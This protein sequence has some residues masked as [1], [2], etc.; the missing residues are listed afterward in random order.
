MQPVAI[1][2]TLRLLYLDVIDVMIY[3]IHTKVAT[4]SRFLE[5]LFVFVRNTSIQRASN[6]LKLFLEKTHA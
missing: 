2:L 5:L 4:F 6:W 3:L 1:T